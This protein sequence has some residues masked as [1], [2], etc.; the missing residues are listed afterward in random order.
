VSL[1]GKKKMR[2]AVLVAGVAA[3]TT[4]VRFL[5]SRRAPHP[6]PA[7]RLPFERHVYIVTAP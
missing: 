5:V 2:L 7:T 1:S 4:T 3:K 6:L